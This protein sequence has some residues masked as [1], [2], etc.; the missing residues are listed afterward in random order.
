VV[1]EGDSEYQ[2]EWVEDSRLYRNQL[3]YL[4]RWMGYDQMTGE[5]AKDIDGLQAIDVFHL[6]YPQKPRPLE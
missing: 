6:K 2:V 4:V 5:P 1:V 3:Q